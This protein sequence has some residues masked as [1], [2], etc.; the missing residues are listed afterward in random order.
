MTLYL[1]TEG[2]Y[3]PWTGEPID[4][5]RHPLSIED[6]WTADELAAIGLYIPAAADPVPLGK[7][8]TGVTVEDVAGVPTYVHQLRD[9][10][11]AEANDEARRLVA[12]HVD[13]VAAARGYDSGAACASYATS[14]V[15][16][17]QSEARV[18]VAWRDAVW[19]QVF[20]I[21]AA[22]EA[23]NATVQTAE[24][25]IADLPVIDWPSAADG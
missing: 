14:T 22:V 5:V 1:K 18:F 23:G 13:A 3:A 10:T 21:L 19:S 15:A 16:K 24:A 12:A 9:R 6:A 17:W 20:A 7:V 4:G 2:A 25:L 8:S 11:L